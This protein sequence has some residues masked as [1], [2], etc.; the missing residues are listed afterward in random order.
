M[1]NSL[2]LVKFGMSNNNIVIPSADS[3]DVVFTATIDETVTSKFKLTFLRQTTAQLATLTLEHGGVIVWVII[4]IVV[5]MLLCLG[6]IVW[7][8][9]FKKKA[10]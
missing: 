9:C 6:I 2:T 4:G 5:F 7:K 3:I 8:S 1:Y 10:H